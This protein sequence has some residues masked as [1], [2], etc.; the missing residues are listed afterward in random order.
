MKVIFIFCEGPH[1][2]SF[3]KVV[4]G[5]DKENFKIYKN[6]LSKYPTPLDEFYKGFYTLFW[7]SVC[8]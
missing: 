3:L 2:I 7:I 1:D 5:L 6:K 8:L 4:L